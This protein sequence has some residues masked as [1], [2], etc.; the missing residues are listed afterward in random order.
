MR[1]QVIISIGCAILILSCSHLAIAE[2]AMRVAASKDQ[3]SVAGAQTWLAMVDKKEY[4]QS[5]EIASTY[6][7]SLVTKEQ[8]VSQIAAVRNP[9]GDLISR[10]LKMN[11][12][13]KTMPG[14]PDGEYYVL[15]FNT[16]F[17]NKISAVEIVTVIKD[18]DGQWRLAGYFIK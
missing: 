4:E 13:Q 14:A 17:K 18:K 7:K 9:L 8:W 10:N 15:T 1:K 12:Y 11:L 2:E 3:T 16:V 6:F 5:W